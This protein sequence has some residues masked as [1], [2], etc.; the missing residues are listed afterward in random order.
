MELFVDG[1]RVLF[2]SAIFM[3]GSITLMATTSTLSS[4]FKVY[5]A[6]NCDATSTCTNTQAGIGNTQNNDCYRNSKCENFVD[7]DG[8]FNRQNNNCLRTEQCANAVEIAPDTGSLN[9]QDVNC[10]NSNECDNTIG[11]NT[12]SSTQHLVC[13]GTDLCHNG[14]AAN[15]FIS[16]TLVCGRT[17]DCINANGAPSTTQTLACANSPG[18][19]NVQGK[20]NI[21]CQSSLC[22]S[23]RFGINEDTQDT[24]C[25]ST[26]SCTN[27]GINT[28]VLSNSATSCNADGNT[29]PD[30]T[31]ICQ[32]DRTFVIPN[33]QSLIYYRSL[34]HLTAKH[35]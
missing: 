24:A 28:R 9:S 27:S 32:R 13:S 8:N 31:I 12:D 3:F 20:T 25:Q 21:A 7:V 16:Q 6:D 30:T 15:D 4:T 29:T 14:A 5:A 35:D 1:N 26:G 23:G 10:V 17:H 18:C 19:E 22:E 11:D 33:H 34:A 2:F